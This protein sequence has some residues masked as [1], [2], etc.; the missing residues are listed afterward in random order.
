MSRGRI[1]SEAPTAGRGCSEH[2][3]AVVP[4][5]RWVPGVTSTA[6]DI[7]VTPVVD[8]MAPPSTTA[9]AGPG[10]ILASGQRVT[11]AV[12]AMTSWPNLA[13]GGVSGGGAVGGLA[14]LV[15]HIPEIE[16][17]GVR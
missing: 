16:G 5:A 14:G 3:A 13:M 4:Q 6:V 11:A 9:R 7:V 2:G 12:L 8:R 1:A 17:R 10:A 15:E